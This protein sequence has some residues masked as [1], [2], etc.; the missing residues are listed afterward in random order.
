MP[1]YPVVPLFSLQL[2]GEGQGRFTVRCPHCNMLHSHRWYGNHVCFDASASCGV[3]KDVRMYRVDLRAALA[4][5]Q[6]KR[7]VSEPH[8]VN[9]ASGEHRDDNA[10]SDVPLLWE[11]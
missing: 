5:K 1:N 7:N 6:T 10:I 4:V 8:I 9:R 11:E 2:S 3:G